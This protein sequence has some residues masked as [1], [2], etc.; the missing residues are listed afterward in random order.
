MFYEQIVFCFSVE[1]GTHAERCVEILGFARPIDLKEC[2]VD[3]IDRARELA[4]QHVRDIAEFAMASLIASLL[5]SQ[6]VHPT[7]VPR[8]PDNMAPAHRRRRRR[9]CGTAA[10]P[11][12]RDTKPYF[13][14]D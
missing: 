4:G 5:S 11:A 14:A 10:A 3:R 12:I 7:A 1:C 9:M 2:G 13:S 8:F 6:I